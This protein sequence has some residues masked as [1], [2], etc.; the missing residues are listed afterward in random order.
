[1]AV[2]GASFDSPQDNLAF[3]ERFGYSGTLL[4]DTDRSVGAAYQTSRPPD[5]PNPQYAKRRTFVIDPE[6][7]I[8]KVYAVKDIAAHP[9]EVLRDLAA[10]GVGAGAG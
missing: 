2:L 5:D 8:R 7:V 4:S 3:A 10:M 6:G 1:V 9:D